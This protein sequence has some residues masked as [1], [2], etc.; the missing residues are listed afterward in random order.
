MH[1]TGAWMV[2]CAV[3]FE[4]KNTLNQKE[5]EQDFSFFE[6]HRHV[7]VTFLYMRSS[8]FFSLQD[9]TK[10]SRQIVF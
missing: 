4:N 9:T 6:I 2:L 8:F 7:H 1:L 5:I 3:L 10:E